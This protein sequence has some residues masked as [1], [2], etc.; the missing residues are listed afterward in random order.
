[1]TRETVIWALEPGETNTAY[2]GVIYGRGQFLS[3]HEIADIVAR[4]AA[5]GFHSFRASHWY[6]ATNIW[7][8]VISRTAR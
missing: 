1:M 5:D 2:E 3:D 7:E 6:P 4:A 8:Q